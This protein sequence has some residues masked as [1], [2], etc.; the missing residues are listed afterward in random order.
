MKRK[1]ILSIV[2][3]VAGVITV[4]A[5]GEERLVV[6]AGN[7]EHVTIANDLNVILVPSENVTNSV[8]LDPVSSDKLDLKLTKNRLFISA[9]RPSREKPTV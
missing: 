5:Q 2:A 6:N 8:S 9:A 1:F 4:S 3:A 7:I